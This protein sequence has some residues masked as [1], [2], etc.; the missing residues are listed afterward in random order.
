MYKIEPVECS[1]C[2]KKAICFLDDDGK[3]ICNNPECK[4]QAIIFGDESEF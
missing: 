2:G 1:I 3:L 4:K